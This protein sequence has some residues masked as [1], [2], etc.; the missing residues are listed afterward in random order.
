LTDLTAQD[1]ATFQD[2]LTKA[3]G[4]KQYEAQWYGLQQAFSEIERLN[5][6]VTSAGNPISMDLS[7]RYKIKG[8]G[9]EQV[10]DSVVNIHTNSA[11]KI[12]TVVDRW[13]DQ[14]PEGVFA[15]ASWAQIFSLRWWLN[16]YIAWA[17]WFWSFVWWTWP[18]LVRFDIC[19]SRSEST[20]LE[21]KY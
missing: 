15:K 11:G 8:I 21:Y 6:T 1:D 2:P 14:L 19:L 4:R 16:Y 7:T 10:I 12:T 5:Q 17:W 3:E 9:K 18:W 20:D 13:S